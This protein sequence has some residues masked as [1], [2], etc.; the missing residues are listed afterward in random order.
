MGIYVFDKDLENFWKC[1]FES[2]VFLSTGLTRTS[3]S[4]F[5]YIQLKIRPFP[6]RVAAFLV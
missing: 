5:F 4:L 2:N 1:L 3:T 6:K